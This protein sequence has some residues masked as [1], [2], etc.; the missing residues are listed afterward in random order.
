MRLQ[1]QRDTG[2]W[3][4]VEYSSFSLGPE[5][6]KYR[7]SVSGFSG[8]EGDALGTAA[9]ASRIANGMQFSTPDQDNDGGPQ[10]CAHSTGWWFRWCSR[11]TLN[12]VN[13]ACWNAY[14]DAWID[15]II[16]SRML[17]KSD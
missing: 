9:S 7:L 13:N 10:H 12:D 6:D 15:N 4:S 16:F 11:S 14:T 3:Y 17:V 8:D 1:I 2:L 5:A